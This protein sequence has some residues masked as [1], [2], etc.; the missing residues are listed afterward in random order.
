MYN[1]YNYFK[2]GVINEEVNQYQAEKRE[3]E[4]NLSTM[5]TLIEQHD[6]TTEIKLDESNYKI[7]FD[8]IKKTIQNLTS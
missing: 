8:N 7:F 3:Y 5:S 4:R 2:E 1:L 6:D